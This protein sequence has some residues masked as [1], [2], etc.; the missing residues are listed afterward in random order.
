[1]DSVNCPGCEA[2]AVNPRTR[3]FGLRSCDECHARFLAQSPQMA[4]A[5]AENAITPRYRD[6]LQIVFGAAWKDGHARVKA[7]AKRMGAAK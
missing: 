5:A 7:W 2:A 1:M 6:A 4:E 3:V